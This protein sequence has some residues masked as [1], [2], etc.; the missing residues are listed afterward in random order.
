M[1]AYP[2]PSDRTLQLQHRHEQLKAYRD[3]A[4][5]LFDDWGRTLILRPP[6]KAVRLALEFGTPVAV[7]QEDIERG[8]RRWAAERRYQ[9]EA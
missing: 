6:F 5:I 3:E 4:T 1:L 2:A 9:A 8:R 7:E